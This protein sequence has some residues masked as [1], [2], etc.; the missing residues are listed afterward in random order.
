MLFSILEMAAIGES[1]SF[2]L[3]ADCIV[4]GV[5]AAGVAFAASRAERLS[6]E[7]I[8]QCPASRA[9]PHG[10]A[11]L[12]RCRH[13]QRARDHFRSRSRGSS[14]AP[15]GLVEEMGDRQ[16]AGHKKGG[17]PA[18]RGML[19]LAP[20]FLLKPMQG[21]ERGAREASFYEEIEVTSVTPCPYLSQTSSA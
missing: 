9:C 13:L 14:H 18:D 20:H 19:L 4:L 11:A 5:I 2:C 3:Q 1:R 15:L 7:E 12:T 6:Q 17:K 10:R 16:V 21:N 8:D